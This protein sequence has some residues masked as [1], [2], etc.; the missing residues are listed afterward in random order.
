MEKFTEFMKGNRT[1]ILAAAG[2]AIQ[3]CVF[4]GFIS[5]EQANQIFGFLG[6]GALAT[7]RAAV[8]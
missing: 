8:K 4:A 2:A 1:Y 5:Q 6:F 3:G 7:L